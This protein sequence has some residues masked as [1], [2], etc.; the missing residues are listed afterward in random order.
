[1]SLEDQILAESDIP[2]PVPVPTPEW[3]SVDGQVHVVRLTTREIASL[4]AWFNA[5]AKPDD[6]LA[7]YAVVACAR[8]K[9]GT[10]PIFS[11]ARVADLAGK[12]GTVVSRIFHAADALNLLTQ[13][14]REP[15]EKN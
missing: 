9:D 7:P 5:T 6:A 1:M 13:A 14:S 8:E 4:W 15:I 3:P 11:R 2:A 12:A 10:T